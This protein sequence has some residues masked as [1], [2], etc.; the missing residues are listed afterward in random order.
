MEFTIHTIKNPDD[1]YFTEFWNIYTASFPL[2]ERR[3]IEQQSAI[4]NKSGYC[5]NVC[6]SDNQI[7]GFIS[8]WTVKEFIFIEHLAIAP[9]FRNKGYGN[10]IL[11]SF[12]AGNPILIILEIEIPVDNTSRARLRFYES[13][14]F[15]MNDHNHF[16]P[17]YHNGHEPVPMKILTYPVEVNDL[18]YQ[19][20]A[21]YQKETVMA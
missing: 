1:P 15:K 21:R 12:I 10:L 20:F 4:I 9:E 17:P 14:C 16:Q 5:L 11:K 7:I 3:T 18:Q 19:Q 6:I 13:L 2:N 8:H